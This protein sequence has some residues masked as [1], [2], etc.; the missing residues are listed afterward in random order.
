MLS[1]MLGSLNRCFG[2]SVL[3][4]LKKIAVHVDFKLFFAASIW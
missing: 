2:R 1:I 3:V 4:G